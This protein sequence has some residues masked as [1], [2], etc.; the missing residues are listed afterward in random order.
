MSNELV[1]TQER[2]AD[3]VGVR[4]EG[5]TEGALNVSRLVYIGSRADDSGPVYRPLSAPHGPVILC[6]AL[7]GQQASTPAINAVA[8]GNSVPERFTAS[9]WSDLRQH[10]DA[11]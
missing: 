8:A 5:V 10:A 7:A 9:T 2:I 3:R 11:L 4:R 6:G 1:M